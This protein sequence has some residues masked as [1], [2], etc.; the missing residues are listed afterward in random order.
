M[1][2][3][4]GV[5]V[6][7]VDTNVRVICVVFQGSPWFQRKGLNKPVLL[8]ADINNNNR[9][10]FN[11]LFVNPNFI[12]C[13][14]SSTESCDIWKTN[15]MFRRDNKNTK[16]TNW[17]AVR[18]ATSITPQR[19]SSTILAITCSENVHAWP[20]IDLHWRVGRDNNRTPAIY[21]KKNNNEKIAISHLRNA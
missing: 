5:A 4:S 21:L 19:L 17:W 3:F 8:T 12:D 7:K 14:V 18:N 2:S 9:P 15:K 1:I 20:W 10:N 16:A 6:D 13:Q 11:Y